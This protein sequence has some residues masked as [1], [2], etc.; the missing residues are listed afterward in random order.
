MSKELEKLNEYAGMLGDELGE[1]CQ[2]LCDLYTR[3]ECMSPAFRYALDIEVHRV[4]KD[5][6]ENY[7]VEKEIV[8]SRAYTYRTLV[9]KC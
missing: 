7:V 3:P 4:V 1:Y 5:L 8:E 6:D 2:Y 9:P